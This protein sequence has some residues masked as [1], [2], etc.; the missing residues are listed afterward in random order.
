MTSLVVSAGLVLGLASAPVPAVELDPGDIL[1]TGVSAL[2]RRVVAVDPVTGGQTP[3]TPNLTFSSPG[4]IEIGPGGAIF[5]ADAGADQIYQVDAATGVAT[6][7]LLAPLNSVLEITVT[8]T[9]RMFAATKNPEQVVEVDIDAGTTALISEGGFLFAPRAIEVEDDGSILVLDL[10][11]LGNG[12]IIRIDPTTGGQ[13]IFA[14]DVALR[15][16]TDM[17]LEANGHIVVSGDDVG[18]ILRVDPVTGMVSNVTPNNTF[19]KPASVTVDRDGSLIVIDQNQVLRVDP[20][21]GD[22]TP[23]TQGGLLFMP[24]DA[25]VFGLGVPILS[26]A[27]FDAP[28][29][30][31][32]VSVSAEGVLALQAEILDENGLPVTGGLAAPPVLETRFSH[33]Q[34]ID[35]PTDATIS[36]FFLSPGVL[37][38]VP[39]LRGNQFFFYGGTSRWVQGLPTEQFVAPGTYTVT[40][41]SGDKDEYVFAPGCLATY[42]VQ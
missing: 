25:A 34:P 24:I 9:G 12:S 21:T 28:L 26:C 3:V 42:V 29:D 36:P 2:D 5:V 4:D 32:P 13:T 7:I 22:V 23:I 1:V 19:S 40:M 27:G 35:P 38:N 11:G 33:R 31:G 17:D 15:L 18:A 41:V 6:P 14:D 10:D 30:L 16:S 39:A 37:N 20:I 8:P